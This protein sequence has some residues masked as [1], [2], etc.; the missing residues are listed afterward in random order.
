MPLFHIAGGGRLT[1]GIVR[2]T[3]TQVLMPDFDP[4]LALALTETYQGV[5][6]GGVPTML[7]AMLGHPSLARRDLSSLRYAMAGGAPVPAKLVRRLE[8]TPGLP[9]VI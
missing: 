4:G 8:A 5:C 3:G 2:T 6:F 1:L 9:F 7:T